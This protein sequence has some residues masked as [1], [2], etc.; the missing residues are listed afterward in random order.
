MKHIGLKYVT[1]VG[2][3]AAI[4]AVLMLFEVPLWFAPSFYELDFS[5]LPILIGGFALG[6]LAAVLI[7]LIKNLL[8]ILMNGSDTA[9]VGE[10][11]NFVTGCAFVLPATLLYK[12]RKTLKMAI[13]GLVLGTLSL[14]IVGSLMNYFVLIPAFSSLYG[15]PIEAI[16]GMYQAIWPGVD[17]LLMC[18]LVFNVPFTC[19]KG[20]LDTLITFLIYKPLS[21]LLRG[22]R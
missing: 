21:P 6:P 15:L 10:C 5:E 19:F 8:N 1:K 20:L 4:A 17:G 9:F 16:V 18:L 22:K 3:L 11:A 7:E 14:A 12:Y 13:F 2:V